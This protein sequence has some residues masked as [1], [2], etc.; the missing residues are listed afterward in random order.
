MEKSKN[1]IWIWVI[2]VAAIIVLFFVFYK[3]GI[4]I[5]TPETQ[6]PN[7][8]EIESS[9]DLSDTTGVGAVSIAYANALEK[10]ADK[11]NPA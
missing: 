7:T 5:P 2:I 10:Y 11:K 4:I 6:T 9:Q 1:N 3:N 8:T